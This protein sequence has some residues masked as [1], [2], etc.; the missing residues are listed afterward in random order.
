MTHTTISISSELLKLARDS[1]INISLASQ[2]GIRI[3]LGLKCPVLPPCLC[4]KAREK[5]QNLL[6]NAQE[7]LLKANEHIKRIENVLEQQKNR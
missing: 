7:E 1:N 2:H 6:L 5:L 3:G 4:F